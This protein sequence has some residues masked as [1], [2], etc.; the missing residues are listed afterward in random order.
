MDI[1]GK[2]VDFGNY[3]N[4]RANKTI[5]PEMNKHD[6]MKLLGRK[7]L[8]YMGI[9]QSRITEE[10]TI[11]HKGKRYRVDLIGPPVVGFGSD[12]FRIAIECGDNKAEKIEALRSMFPLVLIL[13]YKEF[14]MLEESEVKIIKKMLKSYEQQMIDHHF[15]LEKL[16][17]VGEEFT[18]FK[19]KLSEDVQK[20][21]SA[22]IT[23]IDDDL[24]LSRT[25]IASI[26]EEIREFRQELT[27]LKDFKEFCKRFANGRYMD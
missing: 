23:A 16:R 2:P 19:Q 25:E 27:M 1:N 8:F 20:Y 22:S 6:R 12:N 5:R 14:D 11:E 21:K 13:P 9:P 7:I 24:K 17:E 4:P 15:Y 26:K 18:G 10:E 3:L